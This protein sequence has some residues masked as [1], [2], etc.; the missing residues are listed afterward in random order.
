VLRPATGTKV[1]RWI[2]VQTSEH[3]D[4]ILVAAQIVGIQHWWLNELDGDIAAQGLISGPVNGPHR[5]APDL[6]KE[7][8]SA[9]QKD[10][11]ELLTATSDT[12]IPLPRIHR[13]AR[14]V[15]DI[16]VPVSGALW[17]GQMGGGC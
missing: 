5:T 15:T 2:E 8:I 17:P 9:A 3:L 12:C 1:Q 11:V 6:F 10:T 16:P 7:T 14:P 4:F 13:I